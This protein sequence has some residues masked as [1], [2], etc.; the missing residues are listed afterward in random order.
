MLC[1]A[2]LGLILSA[3]ATL[4]SLIISH[5]H[6]RVPHTIQPLV[7]PLLPRTR[8]VSPTTTAT[9]CSTK[10]R[11]LETQNGYNCIGGVCGLS[12][13]V[14]LGARGKGWSRV[15][16]ASGAG[17]RRCWI[18]EILQHPRSWRGVKISGRQERVY[19]EG[20]TN[21]RSSSRTVFTSVRMLPEEVQSEAKRG[22]S[23]SRAPRVTVDCML[24]GRLSQGGE[25]AQCIRRCGVSMAEL[26]ITAR[27]GGV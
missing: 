9:L 1:R 22:G 12:G 16:A 27:Y 18:D 5:T 6:A 10:I 13:F 23:G 15:V 7:R 19:E 24:A 20:E 8:Q 17:G 11:L 14:L 25:W 4:P 21:A 26:S 3:T 2:A